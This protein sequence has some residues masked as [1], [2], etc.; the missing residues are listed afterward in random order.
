MEG[1]L[2]DLMG[3]QK[4]SGRASRP[5]SSAIQALKI[6]IRKSMLKAEI[7]GLSEQKAFM[8]S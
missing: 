4:L 6:K 1:Y 5:S 3:I 2:D 7:K 8:E